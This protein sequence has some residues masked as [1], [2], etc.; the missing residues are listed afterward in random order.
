[1]A[2]QRPSPQFQALVEAAQAYAVA[3]VKEDAT[4]FLLTGFGDPRL[5]DHIVPIWAQYAA[6]PTEAAAAGCESCRYL[7]MWSGNWPNLPPARH[8]NIILFE[9]A[10]MRLS[11]DPVKRCAEIIVHELGHAL[12]RDHVTDAL[13]QLHASGYQLPSGP[14][15][16]NCP[17]DV[18]RT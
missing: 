1:M 10:I 17:S 7:G 14:K 2:R 12:E 4:I 11:G 5:A 9:D 8:G 3:H 18:L 13:E 6:N 15:G 16:C